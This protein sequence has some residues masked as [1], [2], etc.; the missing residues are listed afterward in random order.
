M[1]ERHG[2]PR[3]PHSDQK[4]PP[5][6]A[7]GARLSEDVVTPQERKQKGNILVIDDEPDDLDLLTTILTEH[8]YPVCPAKDGESG[9]E[10]V[11]RR[12]PDLVLVDISLP[13]M[14]GYQ[15]CASLKNDP[16]TRNIPLILIVPIHH[17]I[18]QPKAML[19]GSVDYIASP[20][21]AEEVLWRVET[22]LALHRLR[23]NLESAVLGRATEQTLTCEELERA[24]RETLAL[25]RITG[26]KHAEEK[27]RERESELRQVLDLA[28]QHIAVFGPDGS[29]LFANQAS[30]DYYGLTL[31]SWR[32]CDPGRFLHPDDVERI[33][34]VKQHTDLSDAF[35]HDAEVRLLRKD[36]TYRWFL[37]RR[38]ALLDGRGDLL[39][40][41]VAATD[42]DDRKLSEERLQTENVVLREE[43]D[44]A[45]M[46]EEIVG[47]SR[48]LQ[49][50][51][52]RVAKVAPTET[53][54]LVTG[55]TGTGKELVA[56]AIHR[57]SRR[58]RRAFVS[59]NCAAVP[60][61]LVAS[62]L[63]GH[64]KGAFT[65]AT[66]RR[67]GRFELAEGGTIFLDEVGELPADTQISLL[68]VLQEHEF[69]RLGGAKSIRTDVRVIAAT[70]RDLEAAISAGSFRSDLFYRL[71]VF[72]IVVPSLK[73]RRE[74]IPILVQYFI[75]RFARKAGRKITGINKKSLDLVQAYSWPGNIRELQNVIER[76]LIVSPG[77]IF[78]VDESWL[79]KGVSPRSSR[80]QAPTPVE[81]N[82]SRE[83]EIIEAAL[84]ESRGRVSGPAGAA[85]KLGIPRSTL[86]SR[87][88]ALKI[89]KSQF[90][91]H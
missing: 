5:W 77:D 9:L 73:E 53:T 25:T 52:S 59:M 57:L 2:R 13:G 60:R 40:W 85:C 15:V 33:G 63:F 32:S 34:S 86:E 7:V 19:S 87:I 8:G 51:L 83:R 72:P 38:K 11:K 45:S 76:S 61:D 56:R 1:G 28:P 78:S 64:E 58:S 4:L 41:Y 14:N 29:R 31:E 65:G 18:N 47:N 88:R 22:H 17:S 68:R 26:R 21:D 80:S 48:P 16:I 75:D 36:G 90:K 42:I 62:E 91:F 81:P 67:L 69:E 12:L 89:H 71:N 24:V 20:F 23:A 3:H 74:D 6:R 66:Q 70:N 82:Q 50:V 10:L 54:V 49:T 43:I 46:F 39:R 30:L 27:L 79:S 44:K 37:I 35:A 55:E 84:A